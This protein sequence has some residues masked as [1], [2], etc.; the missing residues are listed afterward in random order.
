[1]KDARRHDAVSLML[2]ERQCVHYR[3]PVCM[4]H[5]S[6]VGRAACIAECILVIRAKKERKEKEK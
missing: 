1:M 5:T 2:V 6:G 4:A 3:M